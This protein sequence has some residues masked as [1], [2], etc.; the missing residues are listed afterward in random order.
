[1]HSGPRKYR[2]DTFGS[3]KAGLL[4]RISLDRDDIRAGVDR[5]ETDGRALARRHGHDVTQ[6]YVENDTSAYKRRRITLPDGSKALRVVRPEY[7]RALQ[8][9]HDGT[10]DILIGYDL[11]RIVRDPRDLEDLIDVCEQTGRT[12]IS[13]TGS[14]QLDTN[15]GITMARVGV[16]VANQSSRDTARRVARAREAAAAEGRWSG[17]G[18]RAYGYT[19]DRTAV[20]PNEADTIARIAGDVLAGHTLNR[21][22]DALNTD[23]VPTVSGS[24]WTGP[25]VRHVVTKPA[26][27][28]LL[29][30]KGEIVGPAPWPAIL[31]QAT[32]Q[33]VVD[34]LSN[35]TPRGDNTL[36]Y[37]LSGI[38]IC[39]HCTMALRG[40]GGRYWCGNA[41]NG[42][43]RGCGKTS[44]IAEPTEDHIAHLLFGRIRRRKIRPTRPATSIAP[45]Q[46]QLVEL[47][48]LWAGKEISLAEYRAA[49]AA[50]VAEQA[51]PKAPA[52]PAWVTSSIED[53]WEG[54][55]PHTM[56]RVAAS[57]LEYVTVLPSPNRRWTPARL[58]P[59][60]WPA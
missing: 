16:A 55:D 46:E 51:P 30:Y 6:L 27:A 22:K 18:R 38:L 35:R 33:Q 49:R 29:T 39:H 20:V 10:I 1:M 7:R 23:Q 36:K 53:D 14:L 9:L 8:D 21:I 50:L 12:A 13:V 17:G 43:T 34:E 57:L 31:D 48:Q 24:P 32:W 3:V 47:A 56:R 26:V 5:Q 58:D 54:Y 45:N 11:D 41:S 25:A 42:H 2:P 44:I 59:H 28:G 15:A 37:W 40:N 52:M 19:S 4:V 60:W